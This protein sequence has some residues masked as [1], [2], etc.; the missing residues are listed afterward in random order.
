MLRCRASRTHT[1]IFRAALASYSGL[2]ACRRCMQTGRT[3]W[4]AELG[5]SRRITL[6]LMF[7]YVELNSSESRHQAFGLPIH[8]F[9]GEVLFPCP[10]LPPVRF[11]Y[12]VPVCGEQLPELPQGLLQ[13][14]LFCIEQHWPNPYAHLQLILHECTRWDSNP[15]YPAYLAGALT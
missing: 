3:I 1:D 5:I 10:A 12:I 4:I 13:S 8:H 14:L 7:A 11:G 2:V 6:R 15:H 9:V